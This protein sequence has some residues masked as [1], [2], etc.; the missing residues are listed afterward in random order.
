MAYPSRDVSSDRAPPRGPFVPGRMRRRSKPR[1]QG[2]LAI[3]SASPRY[4]VPRGRN[5]R[6]M[7]VP[8][9]SNDAGA[10]ARRR[11]EI[12]RQAPMLQSPLLRELA[13]GRCPWRSIDRR[14]EKRRAHQCRQGL[15]M[16]RLVPEPCNRRHSR[17][18]DYKESQARSLRHL[19]AAFQ[20]RP[21]AHKRQQVP[22]PGERRSTPRQT[23]FLR[24]AAPAAHSTY[25]GSAP[26]QQTVR[27]GCAHSL[28]KTVSK[29]DAIQG[30]G[31]NAVLAA[32]RRPRGTPSPSSANNSLAKQCKL[33]S[34]THERLLPC[35]P[36]NR[37]RSRKRYCSFR[38]DA[39]RHERG[40]RDEMGISFVGRTELGWS[41]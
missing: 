6:Q 29:N 7:R 18:S 3:Q 23:S 39:A 11:E 14:I 2:R 38:L 1:Y 16:L 27:V 28:R 22:S 10:S 12:L 31:Q 41:G 21:Q 17:R 40:R 4:R 15:L 26:G 30:R 5:R 9:D 25:L 35:Q 20:L 34:P 24:S 33:A 8:R 19:A 37:Y 13:L 32:R 36:A